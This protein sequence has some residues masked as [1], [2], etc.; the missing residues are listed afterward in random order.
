MVDPRADARE[1]M[2]AARRAAEEKLKRA[3]KPLEKTTDYLRCIPAFVEFACALFDA[4]AR[5][6]LRNATDRRRF[7]AELEAL[8]AR[9]MRTIL[10]D[11][12]LAA[13]RTGRAA[14]ACSCRCLRDS[15]VKR[16]TT[17]VA[18]WVVGG[19]EHVWEYATGAEWE[20]DADGERRPATDPAYGMHGMWERFA[21]TGVKFC[22]RFPTEKEKVRRALQ[23]ALRRA[24]TYWMGR[25]HEQEADA[26]SMPVLEA[27]SSPEELRASAAEPPALIAS[28]SVPARQPELPSAPAPEAAAADQPAETP[29]PSAPRAK[30]R[31][32]GPSANYKTAK[33][34]A[35]IVASFDPQGSGQ[36]RR[37]ENL[38]ELLEALE[39][40]DS[41]GTIPTPN[42]WEEKSIEDWTDA[43]LNAQTRS[44]AKK[45]IQHHLD[46]AG[47][48][49]KL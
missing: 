47:R 34:L 23:S 1:R 29:P 25:F 39:K 40:G 21:P 33:R 13:Q 11:A 16:I 30:G 22:L 2:D 45:A 46:V 4:K 38:D 41:D 6:L 26:A 24:K 20:E 27:S 31:R 18:E 7:E 49:L 8:A 9:I 15:R 32:R 5:E 17:Y 43:G 10:P 42:G 14:I 12:S 35:A 44:L 19:P 36:W 28:A 48:Q 37:S 3:L